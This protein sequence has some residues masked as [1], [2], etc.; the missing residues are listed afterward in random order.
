LLIISFHIQAHGNIEEINNGLQKTE[1]DMHELVNKVATVE[2]NI[3]HTFDARLQQL[4]TDLGN[5]LQT[6]KDKTPASFS[7]AEQQQLQSLVQD[8]QFWNSTLNKKATEWQRTF[9]SL[10]NQVETIQAS[11][12]SL[13]DRYENIST[14]DLHQR[15]VRWF[16]ENYPT[17]HNLIKLV[18]TVQQELL[19][20]RD[21]ANNSNIH[22]LIQH[23]DQ[24]SQLS[25]VAP[26]LADMV[27]TLAGF[28]S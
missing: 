5:E 8:S 3:V 7:S 12:V 22:W 14:D 13:E 25:R 18:Q 19:S 4:R 1:Q 15:M 2:D 6:L 27:R 17:A 16:T 20:L 9:T 10:S 24:L 11:Y 26:E 23:K 28:T 21:F